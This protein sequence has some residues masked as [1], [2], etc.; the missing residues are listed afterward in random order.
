ME[1]KY[2]KTNTICRWRLNGVIYDDFD[3]LYYTYIRT[4]K[5]SHCNKEFKNSL[6]RNLD[7]DH[8]TG[9]FRAI[10]CRTCNNHDSY[11]NYPNGYA[12]K[13]YKERN[14]EKIKENSKQYYITNKEKIKKNV[15][16]YTKKN[17]EK[18]KEY[19]KVYREKKYDCKCGGKYN[20]SHKKEHFNTIKHTAW[21][22]EQVD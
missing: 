20:Q 14:K 8:I 1:S 21:F 3:E 13:I 5:C 11:I 15:N 7:H 16:E 9:L 2:H 10:I 19:Q 4:L 17:K 18:Q 6:D 22:M 12:R